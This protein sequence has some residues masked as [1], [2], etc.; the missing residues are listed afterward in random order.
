[1]TPSSHLVWKL[2]KEQRQGDQVDLL[3]L[4]AVASVVGRASSP[5]WVEL[6]KR[7]PG[8]FDEDRWGK[9]KVNPKTT[10]MDFQT[11]LETNR[12]CDANRS[13][14]VAPFCLGI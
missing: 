11:N 9:V 7:I 1:M 2:W 3:R 14:L 12:T 13:N 10:K 4:V 5:G 6:S 8:T